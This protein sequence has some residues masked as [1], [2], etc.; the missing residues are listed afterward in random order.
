[1][2]LIRVLDVDEKHII[3]LDYNRSRSRSRI[4]FFVIRDLT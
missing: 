1:M 2:C 3:E 4:G